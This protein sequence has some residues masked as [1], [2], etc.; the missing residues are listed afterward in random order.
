LEQKFYSFKEKKSYIL[1][2]MGV[3]IE[4]LVRGQTNLNMRGGT[5]QTYEPQIAIFN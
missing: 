5:I 3:N 2:G 1:A 4:V